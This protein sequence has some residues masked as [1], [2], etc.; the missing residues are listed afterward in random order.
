[1]EEGREKLSQLQSELLL[2]LSNRNK[3]LGF[4]SLG[5]QLSDESYSGTD[6]SLLKSV[7]AQTG[8]ALEN[9]RLMS[10]I[11]KEV[12]HRERLNR[13]VEIA[14]EVQERLFPQTL[15]P[16]VGIEYSGACRTALGGGGDYYDFLALPDRKLGVGL[17]L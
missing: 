14:R 1:S 3:L 12:A 16:I 5:T 6:V 13:E 8:L 15:P 11:A 17:G 7:A 4:T 10:A 2:P 9:A